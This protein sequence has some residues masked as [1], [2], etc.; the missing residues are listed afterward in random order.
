M[1]TFLKVLIFFLLLSQICFA[2]WVQTNG[3]YGCSATALAVSEDNI[4]AGTSVGAFLSTNNGTS[5]MTINSGLPSNANVNDFAF[6]GN[7]IFV[8]TGEGVFRSTNNG[9]SW[10]ATASTIP[11]EV[12]GLAVVGTNLFAGTWWGVYLSTDN[13]SSWVRADSNFSTYIYDFAVIDTNIFAGTFGGRVFLSTNNGLSWTQ[14]DTSNNMNC[15]PAPCFTVIGNNLL[16][17]FGDTLF[18]STDYGTSWTAINSA[19]PPNTHI[20]SLGVS[21]TNLFAGTSTYTETDYECS[22]YLSTDNGT[23]WALSNSGLPLHAS[24]K[25]FAAIGNN[26]FAGTDLGYGIFLSTNNGT[27]WEPVNTGITNTWIYNFEVIGSTLFASTEGWTFISTDKGKNWSCIDGLNNAILSFLVMSNSTGGYDLFAGGDDIYR[28]TDNGIS[29]TALNVG[30]VRSFASIGENI[31][32]GTCRGS[33]FRSTDN[34]TNWMEFNSGLPFEECIDN[35]AVIGTNIFAS[36][37]FS[38]V[39]LSTNNGTSWKAVN[40]GL[41]RDKQIERSYDFISD[42]AVRGGNLF[43][44]TYQGIFLSSDKGLNWT[45]RNSGLNTTTVNSLLVTPTQE[46]DTVLFAGTYYSKVYLSKDDGHSWIDVSE[47]LP[48]TDG[49][50]LIIGS[51]FVHGNNLF[52]GTG[53]RGVWRRPLS[54]MITDVKNATKLPKSF[55]LYQNYPNPFNPTTSVEYRVASTEHVIL[56]VFDVLGSEVATLVNEEK[57]VG[58][59]KVTWNAASLPSG[60]YFYQLKAGC[61]TSTKKLLLLK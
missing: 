25:C 15:C 14:V 26:L 32:A 10:T 6:I 27:N 11:G 7:N 54:E 19:L 4:F 55:A 13:G 18:L 20:G 24:V 33:V 46:G 48:N 23:S 30:W 58:S 2:Q 28:S 43:A 1:K 8:A 44:G 57:P 50:D 29:W 36:T 41:P 22:V 21:G 59:Y 47:G 5:W 38:G 39:F 34:G 17:V 37:H 42:L 56:K 52:A 61:F 51:L 60:V 31:F 12:N 40:N 53:G 9:L 16:A 3:P 35:L 49:S 45:E